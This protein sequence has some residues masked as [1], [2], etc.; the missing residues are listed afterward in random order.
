MPWGA[1]SARFEGEPECRHFLAVPDE[2]RVA[3]QHWMIPRLAV[4]RFEARDL[5]KLIG[6][7]LHQRKFALFRNHEQQIFIFEQDQLAVSVTSAFPRPMAVAEIDARQD[8]AV[9]PEGMTF[10]NDEVVEVGFQA[11]GGP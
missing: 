11:S 4:D 2:E 3:N 7:S 1:R 6:N 10:V 5:G 8:V 9:E